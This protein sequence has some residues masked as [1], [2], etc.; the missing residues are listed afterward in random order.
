MP[1][2]QPGQTLQTGP[3]LTKFEITS[4]MVQGRYCMVRQTIAPGKLFWPHLHLNEDQVIIVLSGRIG[5]RVGDCEW[6][7][8]I[9]DVIYRPR[10]A[11]HAIWNCESSPAE[12][13][14]ITSPGSFEQ[15]FLDL[16]DISGSDDTE[17]LPALL[18]RYEIS[19][20]EGWIGEL[21]AR[22]NVR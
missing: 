19:G 18:R 16:A 12:F 5:A 9:G 4:G 6:S 21:G 20:V 3:L 11:P 7:A 8:G 17:R 1:D 2:V 22:Y 14:E 15:Y 13:L 10:Q